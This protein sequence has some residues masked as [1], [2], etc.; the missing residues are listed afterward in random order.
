M[1]APEAKHKNHPHHKEGTIDY[2][3]KKLKEHEKA[4]LSTFETYRTQWNERSQLSEE[5]SQGSYSQVLPTVQFTDFFT[6]D[7]L[8]K[9]P[10]I[11]NTDDLKKY[12]QLNP[13]DIDVNTF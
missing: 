10:E 8:N 1:G 12:Y 13:Q 5:L 6:S 2:F 4:L 9:K 7:L 3:L 11:S